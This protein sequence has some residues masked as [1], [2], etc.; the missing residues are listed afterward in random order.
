MTRDTVTHKQDYRVEAVPDRETKSHRE[1]TGLQKKRR[2]ENAGRH[3]SAPRLPRGEAAKA[4]AGELNCPAAIEALVLLERIV[5]AERAQRASQTLCAERHN[6]FG[7]WY[8][9]VS[10]REK[11]RR[12]TT[13]RECA[14]GLAVVAAVILPFGYLC[15]VWLAFHRFASGWE[16]LPIHFASLTAFSFLFYKVLERRD[17]KN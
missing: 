1:N 15:G 2:A 17:K 3:G 7:A 9:K 13:R 12:E 11:L 10:Q 6:P 16:L 8:R 14:F 5:V 4:E